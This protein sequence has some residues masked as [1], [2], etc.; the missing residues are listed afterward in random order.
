[1]I[2]DTAVMETQTVSDLATQYRRENKAFRRWADGYGAIRHSDI[3]QMHIYNLANRLQLEHKVVERNEVF[4]ILAAADRIASAAM[5]LVVHMT[6]ALK[7][8]LD[9]RELQAADFK[10]NPQGQTGGSLNMALAYAGYFAANALSA[11]TRAWVSGLGHCV[12]AI[13]A[14][15]LLLTNMAPVHAQRY[16]LSDEGLSRFVKDFYSYEVRSD[17]RPTSPLGSHINPYTAGGIME[18]GYL[19]LAELQYVHMPLPGEHLVAFLSDGGFEEQRGADWSSRWWRA[20][21]CGLVTPIMIAN[22]RRID[23][24]TVIAGKDG[25]SWFHR[26]LEHNQ[27]VP[28][29]IDGHDP[30]SFAWAIIEMEDRLQANIAAIHSGKTHYPVPLPYGV[31]ECIEG[32]GFPGAGSERAHELPLQGNPNTDPGARQDF[33]SGARKLWVKFSVLEESMRMLNHHTTQERPKERD[34]ALAVRQVQSPHLPEP[35]WNPPVNSE[36]LSPLQ[37]I[38][39]YF[40]KII[41]ANAKLRARVGNPDIICSDFLGNTLE[42]LKHRVSDPQIDVA[43]ALDGGIITALNEEA[44]VCA[45]LGNKGGINLVISSEALAVKMLGALRQEITFTRQQ[46][47][48][49][50]HPGWLAVPLIVTSHTWEEGKNDQ[51]HQDTTFCET[52]MNEMSDVSRVLFPADWNTAAAALQ[53]TYCGIGQICT[54]V[55]PKL[56]LPIWF[57][58]DQARQLVEDGAVRLRGSGS[59]DE[60]VILV[61]TGAYQL[62]E[63]LRASER[64]DFA[65]IDHAVIYLQE[66]GRFRIA[67]DAREL[68][69]LTPKEVVNKLFPATASVR[70]FL[71]HTRPEPFIGTIWPLLTNVALTP[72]LGYTNQGGTLNVDGMLFAN[73]CTWAHAVASVALGLGELPEVLLNEDEFAAMTGTGDPKAILEPRLRQIE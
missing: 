1:M 10:P 36:S 55:V 4:R 37:A 70:V 56:E 39:E 62:R 33:N 28:I 11:K 16:H 44:V 69:Y 35:D 71:T 8:H 12:A 24:R 51:S 18:G 13:D 7:V 73:R 27:F 60:Q 50:P 59:H 61:A 9:G 52:M 6:Y 30:A 14:I 41:S 17:G 65:G 54:L 40:C 29:D 57:S 21:D 66:P 42:L 34:H 67:R 72:V 38:D 49:G 19:G 2:N 47:E 5:W 43:E 22:G 3:T 68:E 64:L 31:A 63:A 48:V 15:N 23:Q 45:A 26:H 25:A 32:Y 53:T 20:E 46:R 58:P